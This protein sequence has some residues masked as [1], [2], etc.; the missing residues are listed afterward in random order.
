MRMARTGACRARA[1]STSPTSLTALPCMRGAPPCGVLGTLGPARV[2]GLCVM[3]LSAADCWQ[4]IDMD[5]ELGKLEA[6]YGK[7]NV[8]EADLLSHIMYPQAR[9]SA[10]FTASRRVGASPHVIQPLL[11]YLV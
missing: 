11:T 3:C 5:A 10:A 1:L 6:L 7:G 2:R 4:P 8:S 9:P